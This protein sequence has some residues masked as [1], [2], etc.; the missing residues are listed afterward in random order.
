MSSLSI[1]FDRDRK[2]QFRW[3]D[4]RTICARLNNLSMVEFL[5]RLGATSPDVLHTA[6]FIGLSHDDPKLTGQRLDD[7]I[8]GYIDDG[9]QLTALVN[10]VLEA[11]TEDGLLYSNKKQEGSD[12]A[13][14]TPSL[15]RG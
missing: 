3:S 5:T 2:L 12:P 10:A 14:P 9:G 6:L 1:K 7:L 11:M 15:A 13:N 4:M 8:Q